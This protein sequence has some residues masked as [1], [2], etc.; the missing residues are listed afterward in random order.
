MA[1]SKDKDVSTEVKTNEG[2]KV[3]FAPEVIATIAGL[4]TAEVKGVVGTS[5]NVVEGITEIL[6]KKNLSKGIK[7]DV[8]SEEA[9]VDIN[10]IIEYG[11]KIHEVCQ[12][13][14]RSV[15]KEI[16]TMTGLKVVEVNVFVSSV[17]FEAPSRVDKKEKPKEKEPK[18]VDP[19]RVK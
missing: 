14:Q 15:K 9:A 17:N 12:D 11:Y 7:V 5:G 10:V 1:N 8:G 16:E 19:P 3:I 18:P 2:G 13:V 6:G 4:A